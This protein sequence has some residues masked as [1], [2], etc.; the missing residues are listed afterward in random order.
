MG[1]M[2]DEP[3]TPKESPPKPAEPPDAAPMPQEEPES[4]R[5]PSDYGRSISHE[6]ARPGRSRERISAEHEARSNLSGARFGRAGQVVAGDVYVAE[7]YVSYGGGTGRAPIRLRELSPDELD[8]AVH[9]YLEPEG[10]LGL[11]AAAKASRVLVLRAADGTGRRA[12]AHRLLRDRTS[13]WHLAP[14]TDLRDLRPEDLPEKDGCGYVLADLPAAACPDLNSF[15]L[16]H[17]ADVLESRDGRL[18]ITV[19]QQSCPADGDLGRESQTLGPVS[20]ATDIFQLRVRWRS[21]DR[22]GELLQHAEVDAL[23]A[24]KLAPSAP[25]WEA[26]RLAERLIGALTVSSGDVGEAV[27]A[28]RASLTAPSELTDWFEAIPDLATQCLAIGVAVLGGEPYTTVA[29]LANV[30]QRRLET[31][32]TKDTGRDRTTPFRATRGDRLGWINARLTP[33]TIATRYGDVPGHVV[34]YQD[35]AAPEWVL[36]HVWNE[37]DEIRRD[38]LAWLRTCALHEVPTVRVR[39]GVATGTLARHAFDHILAT[40]IRP[41]ARDDEHWLRAAAAVALRTAADEPDLRPTVRDVVRTW[42]LDESTFLRATA[43]R[44]W[45]VEDEPLAFLEELAGSDELDVV[46]GICESVSEILEE[47]GLEH[48]AAT[49]ARLTSWVGG[50]SLARQATGRLAF[51]LA[52]GDLVRQ[53]TTPDHQTVTWPTLLHI[54]A[55]DEER[56]RQ[57]A[58]L[59][60]NVLTSSDLHDTAQVILAEWA[61]QAEG[62]RAMQRYLGRL[63]AVAQ[64]Q[65]P[66]AGEIAATAARRWAT[67]SRAAP[68]TSAAVLT[69]LDHHA[70]PRGSR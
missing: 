50:R 15:H 34:R 48:V 1:A 46:E 37:Y 51:L 31:E 22:A 3:G 5:K 19:D 18:V 10:F 64:A 53:F 62:T 63:L 44:A 54:A 26:A 58:A 4:V 36:L 49:L 70:Q 25:P 24:Q 45:R 6:A 30:L 43:A 17:L 16:R 20:S 69:A 21:P 40:T 13:V 28:V 38:L 23:V 47:G 60:A 39:A 68:E 32:V 56:Q 65:D 9:A 66:R 59:W 61:F 7:Q 27:R 12:A 14:E 8:A 33:S 2:S 35:P 42:S 41:W 11:V 29:S 57:V 52:A 67:G 55:R